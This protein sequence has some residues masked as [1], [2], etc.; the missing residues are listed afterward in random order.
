ML[1]HLLLLHP[2][3]VISFA[4]L[5]SLCVTLSPVATIAQMGIMLPIALTL[6]NGSITVKDFLSN[7]DIPTGMDSYSKHYTVSLNVGDS[8]SINVSSD[9]L[10]TEVKLVSPDIETVAENDDET[11]DSTNSSLVT[12]VEKAGTYTIIVS[13]FRTI[14]R[15]G[16]VE[17][18]FTLKVAKV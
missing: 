17:G 9:V 11:E 10:D 7:K 5:T 12:K 18:E 4:A 13:S 3:R 2:L 14:S 16:P 6:T 8:I 1:K 15:P